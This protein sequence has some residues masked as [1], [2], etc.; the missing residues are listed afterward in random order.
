MDEGT[1]MGGRPSIVG[2]GP[3]VEVKLS[4]HAFI[5]A[6]RYELL[7]FR[8]QGLRHTLAALRVPKQ[9]HGNA[10]AFARQHTVVVLV[11][12]VPYFREHSRRELRTAEYL[13]RGLASDD[14]KFLRISLGK[15]RV[16]ERD[17]LGRWDE[18]GHGNNLE[19]VH[20]LSRS[21]G[22]ADVHQRLSS[23]DAPEAVGVPASD[24]RA[25]VRQQP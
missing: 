19:L 18:L 3:A 2:I 23:S 21:R 9:A 20:A 5:P 6:G 24:P 17:L 4:A 8:H 25:L 10:N 14:P 16:N 7:T 22:R 11:R 13:D 1:E 12:E 15:Y